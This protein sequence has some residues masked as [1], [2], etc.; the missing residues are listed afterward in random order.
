LHQLVTTQGSALEKVL[1]PI[2]HLSK[3]EVKAIAARRLPDLRVLSKPESMGIC[4]IGKRDMRDFLDDY[5]TLTPGRYFL[6]AA[7]LTPL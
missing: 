5:I 6:V 7:L 2:G 3:A 4:F 1:L